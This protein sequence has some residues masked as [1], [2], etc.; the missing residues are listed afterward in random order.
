LLTPE[1]L[2]QIGKVDVLLIT[3]CGFCAITPTQAATVRQQLQPTITIPM[4][5]RTRGAGIFGLFY[6]RVNQFL[7]VTGEP[8]RQTRELSVDSMSLTQHAGIVVMNI[9]E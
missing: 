3:I 9:T 1:H 4:H 8:A 2:N 6:A 7:A 5:Y